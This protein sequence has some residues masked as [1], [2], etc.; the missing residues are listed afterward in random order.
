M[1]GRQA[2]CFIPAQFMQVDKEATGEI[3]AESTRNE[4][5][6]FGRLKGIWI[7]G[8]KQTWNGNT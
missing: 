6:V 3:E 8:V 1:Y 5:K 4:N 7:T 2:L